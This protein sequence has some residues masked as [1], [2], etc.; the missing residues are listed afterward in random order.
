MQK[1][2]KQDKLGVNQPLSKELVGEGYCSS[3]VVSCCY[4]KLVAE[5]T[6]RKIVKKY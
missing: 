3:V 4:E 6:T 2:Y 1:C 5:A